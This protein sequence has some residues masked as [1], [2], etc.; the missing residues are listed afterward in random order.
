MIKK[1]IGKIKQIL[2]VVFF[3]LAYMWLILSEIDTL[4]LFPFTFEWTVLINWSKILI[5]LLLG[6]LCVF[7][8]LSEERLKQHNWRILVMFLILVNSL[9]L[10]FTINS[11]ISDLDIYYTFFCLVTL[12]LLF[13]YIYKSK[14][15]SVL[16]NYIDTTPY[17]FIRAF[18]TEKEYFNMAVIFAVVSLVILTLLMKDFKYEQFGTAFLDIS[19]TI[20]GGFFSILIYYKIEDKTISLGDYMNKFIKILENADERNE[21][22]IVSPTLFVGQEFYGRLHEKYKQTLL[23]K[24]GK[25]NLTIANLSFNK[26]VLSSENCDILIDGNNVNVNDNMLN[27]WMEDIK[28]FSNVSGTASD[29]DELIINKNT[30]VSNFECL[31]ERYSGEN[32]GLYS[33]HS[34]FVPIKRHG[35]SP[36]DLQN[37]IE[38]HLKLTSFYKELLIKAKTENSSYTRFKFLNWLYFQKP[39]Y[40]KSYITSSEKNG[41][42][43]EE[44]DNLLNKTIIEKKQSSNFFAVANISKGEYYIGQ[45]HVSSNKAHEFRGTSFINTNISKQMQEMLDGFINEYPIAANGTGTN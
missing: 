15:A 25:V 23:N 17:N 22:Y 2:I 3:L 21:I 29:I 16:K 7:Q 44:V 6:I 1:V 30:S 19:Y 35:L 12:L 42:I 5:I 39:E 36:I 26:E 28:K 4:T 32:L 38:H 9:F 13:H 37:N 34:A 43:K 40:T 14:F 20:I 33:F 41:D 24:I 10:A 27:T 18:A 45:F 11:K 8:F 31:F